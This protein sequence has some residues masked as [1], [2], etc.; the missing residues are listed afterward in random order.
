[1]HI[2]PT[3]TITTLTAHYVA[4]LFEGRSLPAKCLSMG[5]FI[6]CSTLLWPFKFL[7]R[8]LIKKRGAHRLAFG[9]FVTGRVPTGA[10]P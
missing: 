1:M 8:W 9:V 2:G 5:A 7:D 3:T 4:L 10:A 6:V